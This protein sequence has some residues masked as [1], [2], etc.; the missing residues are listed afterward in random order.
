MLLS[1]SQLQNRQLELDRQQQLSALELELKMDEMR[2]NRKKNHREIALKQELEELRYDQSDS[3]ELRKKRQAE[4][5]REEEEA[6]QRFKELQEHQ[7]KQ[8]QDQLK[9]H[10]SHLQGRLT[11][12][13]QKDMK[14]KEK[15]LEGKRLALKEKLE[16]DITELQHKQEIERLS[17]LL[18]QER[19]LFIAKL[20]SHF[21][22][23]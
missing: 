19:T 8:L 23:L 4:F 10:D 11:R 6:F 21:V 7:R 14:E 3:K 16:K 20:V 22:V 13:Q 9:L 5:D 1:L 15:E 12:R 17:T 2:Y 18:T